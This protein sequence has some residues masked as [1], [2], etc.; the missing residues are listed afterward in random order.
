VALPILSAAGI[1]TSVLPT[2]VL[3][4]HTGGFTGYTYRDLTDD[5]E[6]VLN[7]LKSLGMHFDAIYTGYLGSIEQVDLVKRVIEE[8]R[9]K[10]DDTIKTMDALTLPMRPNAQNNSEPIS[11][12]NTAIQSAK[13][14]GKSVNTGDLTSAND[15]NIHSHVT[16]TSSLQSQSDLNCSDQLSSS[17]MKDRI[18]SANHARDTL[19]DSID[20]NYKS[21]AR[22]DAVSKSIAT[23]NIENTVN[24]TIVIV[25]P[26]MADKGKLYSLFDK[27]FPKKMR[28]LCEIADVI[29]PNLTEAKL[30]L[31]EEYTGDHVDDLEARAIL[32]RL[33]NSLNVSETVLTGVG[34]KDFTGNDSYGAA[35]YNKIDGRFSIYG[36]EKIA[37]MYH[38]TGDVWASVFTAALVK[39]KPIAEAVKIAVHFTKESIRRSFEG[40]A[41]NRYGVNFEEGLGDLAKQLAD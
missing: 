34:F 30:L 26:A 33:S 39:G 8:L 15:A 13:S 5:I 22:L 10:T 21:D 31:G 24:D 14:D 17:Q 16:S 4:T 9:T 29:V 6:P 36:E 19:A 2:A 7:H 37:N 40:D 41:D 25:D 27:N 18:Q 3:S 12:A 32:K 1:E 11:A 35:S 38:G 28:E 23:S 20:W